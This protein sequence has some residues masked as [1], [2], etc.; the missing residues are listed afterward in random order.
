[1][2]RSG[3][4][5][6][7]GCTERNK[8]I[9]SDRCNWTALVVRARPPPC[10]CFP[11]SS[12]ANKAQGVCASPPLGRWGQTACAVWLFIALCSLKWDVMPGR[13]HDP[14]CCNA[15]R[16]EEG[17]G[18]RVCWEG[19]KLSGRDALMETRKQKYQRL[20]E[21]RRQMLH[22]VL[23]LCFVFRLL[24]G[25]WTELWMKYTAMKTVWNKP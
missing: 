21:M 22:R 12:A 20:R 4:G 8:L 16:E 3:G 5:Q 11:H 10:Y 24:S 2:E 18:E 9:R 1:M 23:F 7:H 19:A 6:Y 25:I 14:R 17:R 15:R 13:S